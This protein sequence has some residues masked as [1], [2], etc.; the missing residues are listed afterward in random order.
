ML[1]RHRHRQIQ[2]V[3]LLDT[4]ASCQPQPPNVFGLILKAVAVAV[5]EQ[6]RV[7]VKK[8]DKKVTV[9]YKIV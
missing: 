7:N 5:Q 6:V 8:W 4:E 3:T 2:E 1:K 9:Y